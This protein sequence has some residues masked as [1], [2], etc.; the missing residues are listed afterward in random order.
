MNDSSREAGSEFDTVDF[1]NGL[2]TVSLS[3]SLSF[4]SL[5]I[6]IFKKETVTEMVRSSKAYCP[7][8]RERKSNNDQLIVMLIL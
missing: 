2:K 5:P 7:L 3:P 4:S 1:S 6:D 8:I